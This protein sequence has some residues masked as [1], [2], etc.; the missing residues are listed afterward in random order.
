MRAIMK[1]LLAKPCVM[2]ALEAKANDPNL[3]EKKESFKHTV[4]PEAKAAGFECLYF[5]PLDVDSINWNPMDLDPTSFASSIVQDVNSLPPEEQH[6]AE[7]DHGYICGLARLLKWGAVQVVRD[8]ENGQPAEFAPLPCNPR[9]MMKLVNSRRNIVESLRRLKGMPEVDQAEL[10]EQ[11]LTLSSIIRTDTDWDKNIQGVRGRL[12][13]FR[14]ESVLRCTEQ[15]NVDLKA[16]MH[17]PTVLIFGAPASLGPDAESLAACFVYQL[18]Q[19]LHTRYGT[20]S[21]LP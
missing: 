5:N 18:Q 2:I 1:A 11:T 14:N 12:R 19:A 17:K 6:W 7:R 16:A 9:G 3:D 4:L 20:A 15:S 8:D 21:V 10:N 13:M